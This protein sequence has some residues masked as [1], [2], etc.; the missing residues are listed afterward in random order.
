MQA[1]K[2]LHI[3]FNFQRVLDD[4][5]G[6]LLFN[7]I[8][9]SMYNDINAIFIFFEVKSTSLYVLFVVVTDSQLYI[10][11]GFS[12]GNSIL[13]LHV[14]WRKMLL[15]CI[16]L[17]VVAK[18][19]VICI[20]MFVLVNYALYCILLFVM[21]KKVEFSLIIC[22]LSMMYRIKYYY[23]TN[24]YHNMNYYYLCEVK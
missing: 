18:E 23:M 2:Q 20:I 1:V 21:V 17:F 16:V 11:A 8:Y 24:Y 4:R 13:C 15:I 5:L 19:A 14:L 7:V 22:I 9:A 6:I 12:E 10:S 3:N